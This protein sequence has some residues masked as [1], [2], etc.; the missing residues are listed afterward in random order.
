M[1]FKAVSSV[2]EQLRPIHC[3]LGMLTIVLC[4]MV[5]SINNP[6]GYINFWFC[7]LIDLIIVG[8]PR[9]PEGL[10]IVNLII[11]F[12]VSFPQVGY[13]ILLEVLST[14]LLMFGSVVTIKLIKFVRG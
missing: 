8:M 4:F 13:G 10:K 12:G 3:V 1:L 7:N 2:F 9:T 14:L 11:D 5:E 6:Q